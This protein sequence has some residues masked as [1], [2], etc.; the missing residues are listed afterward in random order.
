MLIAWQRPVAF[1]AE[2]T[3]EEPIHI[4]SFP[5]TEP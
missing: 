5:E 4:L 2:L 3:V 1:C